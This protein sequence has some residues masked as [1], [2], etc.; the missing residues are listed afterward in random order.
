MRDV[1]DTTF[2]IS[3]LVEFSLKCDS[4]FENL[5]QE[6][7]PHSTGLR[8]LCPSRWSVRA[9]SLQSV[10]DGYTVLLPGD[11]RSGNPHKL[12]RPS[13]LVHLST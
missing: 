13:L 8:V 11:F 12:C 10:L 2:E 9:E 1:C 3:K 7:A 6:L 4:R 5:K